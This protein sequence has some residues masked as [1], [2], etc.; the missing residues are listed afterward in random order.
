MLQTT[1]L[2]SAAARTSTVPSATWWWASAAATPR[3][4]SNQVSPDWGQNRQRN[5]LWIPEEAPVCSDWCCDWVIRWQYLIKLILGNSSLCNLPREISCVSCFSRGKVGQLLT[6]F[7]AFKALIC[8]E[9][10]ILQSDNN[11]LLPVLLNISV[12]YKWTKLSAW[13]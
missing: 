10:K 13:F 8:E 2:S 1:Q 12:V 3:S 7:S 5:V 9:R 4:Y 6:E 11:L